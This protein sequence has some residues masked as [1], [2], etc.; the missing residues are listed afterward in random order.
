MRIA[1]I[2]SGVMG[3]G[4]AYAAIVAGKSVMLYDN[5]SKAL[6]KGVQQIRGIGE[7]GIE[8]G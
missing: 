5:D 4:I 7:K 2:G 1:V 8:R 6:E 3:I